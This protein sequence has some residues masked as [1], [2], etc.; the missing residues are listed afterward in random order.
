DKITQIP[1]VKA[2]EGTNYQVIKGPGF[3]GGDLVNLKTYGSLNI[4]LT[5]PMPS[6]NYRLRIRYAS[7]EQKRIRL[8]ILRNNVWSEYGDFDIPTTYSGNQLT[9]DSFKIFTVSTVLFSS[10]SILYIERIDPFSELLTIDKI[11]LIPITGSVEEYEANQKV[12]KARKVVNALFSNTVKQRLRDNLMGID[13]DI[14][15]GLVEEI[16][17]DRFP[18]EKM[19]LRDQIKQAK[20]MSQSRNL[21][22][23][24]DFASPD[25]SGENGWT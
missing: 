8:R 18:K 4:S 17:D 1:A 20:R 21:L 24:G 16:P 25:W 6:L 3:T 9:F 11:E 7:K 10:T 19:I 23:S 13:L 14:A 12:E 15:M 5:V 2:S 22:Q